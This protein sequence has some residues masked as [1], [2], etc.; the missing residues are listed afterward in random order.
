MSDMSQ[1]QIKHAV[2]AA[3]AA[4]GLPL[5]AED[6]ERLL[7]NYP[8]IQSQLATLRIPEARY[9]EPAMYFRP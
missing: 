6:Y 7:G 8:I 5:T 2:D 4:A 3:V 9:A 1:E